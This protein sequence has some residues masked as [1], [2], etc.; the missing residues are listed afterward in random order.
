[1]SIIGIA[2]K[3]EEIYFPNDSVPL[4]LDKRSQSLKLI[5][6]LR[7]EAHRFGIQHHR[8]KR[9]KSS[10]KT[11]LSGIKGISPETEKILLRKFKSMKKIKELSVEELAE[12]TGQKKAELI[13]QHIH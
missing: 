11:E 4:Y 12:V 10:L 13:H 3:L 9:S 8:D 7:N 5:Q 2:K 1:M 6:H